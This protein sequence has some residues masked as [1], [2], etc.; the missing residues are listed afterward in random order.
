MD[1]VLFPFAILCS[2]FMTSDSIYFKQLAIF[3]SQNGFTALHITCEYGHT[4]IAQLLIDAGADIHAPTRVGVIGREPM[5]RA[6]MY[7]GTICQ[8][9][10]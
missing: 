2:W 5:Y 8:L 1:A 4:Q 10:C 3:F 6:T 9:T 7:S